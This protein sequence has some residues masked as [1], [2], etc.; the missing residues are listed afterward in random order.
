MKS[1]FEKSDFSIPRLTAELPD[2]GFFVVLL[3]NVDGMR[4]LW[5]NL[6]T[7]GPLVS[8]SALMMF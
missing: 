5:V 4:E 2:V 1:L 6:A 8:I 7:I 3:I